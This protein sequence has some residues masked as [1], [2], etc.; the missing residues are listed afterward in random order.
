M[1]NAMEEIGVIET[2]DDNG[3]F[4]LGRAGPGFFDQA[5]ASVRLF[6]TNGF[7]VWNIFLG[8][9]QTKTMIR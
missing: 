7:L 9:I 5:K 6:L 3:V 8:A 2:S 4:C 1:C